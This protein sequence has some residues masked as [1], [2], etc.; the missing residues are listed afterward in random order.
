MFSFSIKVG[1][2]KGSNLRKKVNFKY[3]GYPVGFVMSSFEEKACKF[4]QRTKRTPN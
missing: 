4:L 2:D 1:T 3:V